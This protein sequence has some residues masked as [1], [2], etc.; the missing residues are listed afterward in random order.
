MINPKFLSG[1]SQS[2]WLLL[3][4]EIIPSLWASPMALRLQAQTGPQW[5]SGQGSPLALGLPVVLRALG[6]ALE[7][8][9][10]LR[11]AG[12]GGMRALWGSRGWE[13]CLLWS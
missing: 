1:S 10:P 11:E 8:W 12:A 7:G 4:G 9:I 5:A 6:M 13:Q 2:S 3:G